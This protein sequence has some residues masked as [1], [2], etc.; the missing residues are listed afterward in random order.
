MPILW[1]I[2]F[3]IPFPGSGGGIATAGFRS[4]YFGSGAG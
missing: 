2:P 1:W 4:P 3:G